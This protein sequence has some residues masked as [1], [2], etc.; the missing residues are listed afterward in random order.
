MNILEQKRKNANLTQK[1]M[2]NKLKIAISTYYQYE[3]RTRI[4]PSSYAYEIAKA[5]NCDVLDI[6]TPE[7]FTVSKN[8]VN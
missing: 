6:F 3:I 8:I 4:I 5:L 7:K 1:Y 2:A